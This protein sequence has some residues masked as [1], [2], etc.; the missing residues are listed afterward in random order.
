V[1]V[2]PSFEERNK[3]VSVNLRI[4]ENFTQSRASSRSGSRSKPAHLI[5]RA[6]AIS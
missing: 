2:N 6:V 4:V 3:T 1:L 5:R